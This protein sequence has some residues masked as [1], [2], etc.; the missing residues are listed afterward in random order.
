MKVNWLELI[1]DSE[2]SGLTTDDV[3]VKKFILNGLM[4]ALLED[5][6]DPTAR[7]ILSKEDSCSV[8]MY[9]KVNKKNLSFQLLE[10]YGC[11][12]LDE[13]KKIKN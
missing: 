7:V 4:R 3:P 5:N 2:P 8:I 6:Y 12:Y 13:E 11:D 9:A 10:K 1:V